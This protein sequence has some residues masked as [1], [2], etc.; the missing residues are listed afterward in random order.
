MF[1]KKF[2]NIKKRC[3]DW[4]NNNNI[5]III[6]IIIIIII[7]ILPFKNAYEA[8]ICYSLRSVFT[9]ICFMFPAIGRLILYLLH[10]SPRPSLQQ[11]LR[12]NSCVM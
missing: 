5:T 11:S 12:N 7:N 4:F 6:I 9:V 8:M 2:I 10:H 1:N 3:V